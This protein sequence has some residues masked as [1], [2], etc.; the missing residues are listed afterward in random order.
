MVEDLLERAS[1]S[2][3]DAAG[4]EAEEDCEEVVDVAV[5]ALAALT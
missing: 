2:L 1:R 4:L 5:E 3:A